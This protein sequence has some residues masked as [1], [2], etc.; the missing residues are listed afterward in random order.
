MIIDAALRTWKQRE[1]YKASRESF[2]EDDGLIEDQDPERLQ[3]DIGTMIG[4]FNV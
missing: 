3:E 2:Y 4:L 1:G